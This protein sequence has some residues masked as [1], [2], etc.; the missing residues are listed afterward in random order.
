MDCNMPGFSV[1]YYLGVCS[2][3]C[4]LS[5]WCH[6][7]ISSSV[8]RFSSCPQS[9]PASGS[10]QM[11]WTCA[12][13]GQSIGASASVL[14]V[15]IQG[16]FPLGLTGWPPCCQRDSQESSPAPQFKS[17]NLALGLLSVQLS[18]PYMT[19]G[20]YD[21]DYMVLWQK[22]EVFCFLIYC[23]G[24]H[25]FPFKE[26]TCVCIKSL[27]SRLTLCDPMDHSPPGSSVHGILQARILE[28]VTM[29]SF[30]ESSQ[31]RDGI[32]I[33]YVFCIDLQVLYH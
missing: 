13:G 12:S 18:H 10:F 3:S 25:N 15:T 1:P 4:P 29:P 19:A 23:L 28:W 17:I 14:P 8:A 32:S 31:C 22:S 16:W 21:H 24:C 27:Q 30:R 6:P 11:S 33:S 5:W 2:D 7:T 9:F 20:L 26:H